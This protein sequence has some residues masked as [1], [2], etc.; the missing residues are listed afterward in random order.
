MSG[1]KFLSDPNLAPTR[2][3]TATWLNYYRAMQRIRNLEERLIEL[4]E[5][6]A[7]PGFMHLSLGQESVPVALSAHLRD[8]DTI[9]LTHRSHAQA[10]AKGMAPS[11]LLAELLGLDNG[12][13]RGRGGSMHLAD[14]SI[15]ILGAN[16]IVGAGLPIAAGS[17]LAHKLDRSDNISTAYFGD[18]ALAEGVFHECFNLCALWTLPCLFVCENNGWS[19]YSPSDSQFRGSLK[20]LAA[21]FGIDYHFIDGADVVALAEIAGQLVSSI[22]STSNPQILEVSVVRLHGHHAGDT[23]AYR[24]ADDLAAAKLRDPITLLRARLLEAGLQS[25][26]EKIDTAVGKEINA[27]L[28]TART[29][30]APNFS[31]TE[32]YAT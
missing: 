30:S 24:D 4:N 10:I 8:E 1:D 26:I 6:G 28:A 3:E 13:C 29:G 23:Q 27:A 12:I 18:G 22:R 7:I 25:S 31:L 5:D 2:T 14:T 20:Q 9:T 15:G 21:A 16:G 19:E 11:A 17:A 32:V